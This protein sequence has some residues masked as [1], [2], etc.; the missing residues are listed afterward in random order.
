MATLDDLAKVIAP[1]DVTTL[2]NLFAQ[3]AVI[4]DLT[5]QQNKIDQMISDRDAA[6]LQAANDIAAEQAILK[7]MQEQS[8]SG[9][10][11]KVA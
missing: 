6:N 2:E 4:V 7:Q 3:S 11:I 5:Q 1:M 8:K 10:V 9:G